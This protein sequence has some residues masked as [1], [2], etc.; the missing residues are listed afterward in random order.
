MLENQ[1]LLQRT[2]TALDE[3]R[4]LYTASR[5]ITS[6]Q[7]IAAVY[8]AASEHLAQSAQ[9]IER[10]TV[11]LAGPHAEVGASYFDVAYTWSRVPQA[12]APVYDRMRLSAEALPIGK[13]MA[14]AKDSLYFDDLSTNLAHR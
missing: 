3:T 9:Q 14:V 8:K 12:N 2:S 5:A 6:A 10:M 13:L 11:L 7:D 4:R 1:R